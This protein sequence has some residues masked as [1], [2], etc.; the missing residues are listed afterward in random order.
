M[1]LIL[2]SQEDSSHKKLRLWLFE[3]MIPNPSKTVRKT[4]GSYVRMREIMQQ[5]IY[6][7][8][9]MKT[10]ENPDNLDNQVRY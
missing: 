7:E 6:P 9:K 10:K 1:L 5:N 3:T 2:N 4:A 8:G